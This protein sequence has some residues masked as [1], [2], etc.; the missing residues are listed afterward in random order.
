MKIDDI[1]WVFEQGIGDEF[2]VSYLPYYET[3]SGV[4]NLTT[5]TFTLLEINHRGVYVKTE[6]NKLI[7][8]PFNRIEEVTKIL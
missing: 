1:R 3:L 7:F 8:I 2:R 4:R 6:Y 5:G